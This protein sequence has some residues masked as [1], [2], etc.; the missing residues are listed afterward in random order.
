[1]KKYKRNEPCWCG[2]GKKY[3][4]CHLKLQK[5]SRPHPAGYSGDFAKKLNKYAV[6]FHPDEA[7]CSDE[8]I[9]AHSL[10]RKSMLGTIK[11]SQNKVRTFGGVSGRD[12]K[13]LKDGGIKSRLVGWKEAS[14][15]RGFCGKHDDE[16]FRELDK[17]GGKLFRST[18]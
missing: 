10:S 14:V 4:H 9:N 16:L 11:N 1:M 17:G 6:C 2:S 18:M 5:Q 15:F 12:S 7:S 8:I 13:P 3:K